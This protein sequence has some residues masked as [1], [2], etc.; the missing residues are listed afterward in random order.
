ML[1]DLV[2]QIIHPKMQAFRECFY[3]FTITFGES[4]V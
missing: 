4:P 1:F 2:H 3:N